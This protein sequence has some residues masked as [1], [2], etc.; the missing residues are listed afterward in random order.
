MEG[1]EMLTQ[2]FTHAFFMTFDKKEDYTAFQSHPN[3]VAYSATFSSAIEKI[4]VLDFPTVG[5]KAPA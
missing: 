3:H 1:P 4:V 2:G 5:F